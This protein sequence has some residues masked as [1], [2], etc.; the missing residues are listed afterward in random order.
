MQ[1]KLTGIQKQDGAYRLTYD[2]PDGQKTLKA[3]C[4]ALTVPAYVAADLLQKQVCRCFLHEYCIHSCL[5]A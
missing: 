1:W 3:R 5:M 2:T 4:V